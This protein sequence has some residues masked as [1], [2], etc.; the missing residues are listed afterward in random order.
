M[1]QKQPAPKSIR[2]ARHPG[3][4]QTMNIDDHITVG[5]HHADGDVMLSSE[6]RRR[7]LYIVGQTGTGKSTLLLNLLQQDIASGG[8]LMLLDPH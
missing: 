5:F 1:D 6:E 8:G 4:I 7:H 2:R 3:S